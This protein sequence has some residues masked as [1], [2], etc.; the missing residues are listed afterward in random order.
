M[1][2]ATDIVI[3][4]DQSEGTTHQVGQ[5]LKQ[6]GDAVRKDEPL[7]EIIT[8]K[9]TVEIAAPADGVLLE[10]LKQPGDELAV[11]DVLGRIGAGA[12]ATGRTAEF[13]PPRPAPGTS[14]GEAAEL[15]PAVRRLIQERGLDAA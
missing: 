7:V 12:P 8:D 13:V 6:V 5:W 2:S 1:A 10:I 14:S 4:P 9:V 3:P 11:S 15:S